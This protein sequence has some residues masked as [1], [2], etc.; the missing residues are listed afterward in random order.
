MKHAD[1]VHLHVHTQYSLLDGACLLDRLVDKAV[2]YKLPALAITDHGNMFG[3]IKF[4]NLCM[5]KGV[6]PI[7][8]CEVYV[9]GDSRFNR[10]YKP[11]A[12]TNNHLVLL[13]KDEVG[14]KNLIKL[15]SLAY[16]EG[17]YYK[18]RVDKELL[19]QYSQGL[20]ASSACL[21]GEI[22]CS[23]LAGDISSAYKITDDYLNIFGKDNFYLE[24]MENGLPEQNTVNKTLIDISKDLNV[25]LIATNDVHYIEPEAAIAQE[26]LLCIQTQT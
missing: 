22:P 14:Y 26:V 23:I 5:K 15:T 1:F 16:T 10:E 11:G 25:P 20:I 6:K 13:V 19:S 2:K 24:L 9:A 18:P 17:F 3:A 21:K 8:G 12:N 4:Y 7:I